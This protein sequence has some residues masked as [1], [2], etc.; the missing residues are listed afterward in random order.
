MYPR[1]ISHIFVL[2][3]ISVLLTEIL[4]L[5]IGLCN[6]QELFQSSVIARFVLIGFPLVVV[7]L[8]VWWRNQKCD[9]DH[10]MVTN[11]NK[12]I[13]ISLIG[14]LL[15][16]E[17]SEVLRM[18][19]SVQHPYLYGSW[20]NLISMVVLGPILEEWIFRGIYLKG[21]LVSSQHRNWV[22]VAFVSILFGVI[23]FDVLQGLSLNNVMHVV[24][25]IV[26]G[27]ALSVLYLKFGSLLINV[28]I[29]ILINGLGVVLSVCCSSCESQSWNLVV[30]YGLF[31][32]M[33]PF[34][35]V[36]LKRLWYLS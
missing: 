24:Y 18:G 29:H 19:F 3:G 1:K 6:K 2:L 34:L 33:I 36:S 17:T 26:I 31:I 11:A 13:V 9:F 25:A 15:L 4:M 28:L 14:T 35:Y 30:G 23:H 21:L 16:I 12:S 8:V 10:V 20:V 5:I 27:F 7:H 22:A 32:L